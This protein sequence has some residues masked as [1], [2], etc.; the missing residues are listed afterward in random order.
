MNYPQY[1]P[2]KYTIWA[3]PHPY[4]LLFVLNPGIAINE[5]ILGQRKP[6][7]TLI[8]NTI[9]KP[10]IERIFIPCPHCGKLHDA[11]LWDNKN[12]FGHWFGYV[13]PACSEIIP[14]LWNLT[15]LVILAIT[16][17]IWFIPARLWKSKW[18][19]F[20][21]TRF[22]KSP[23]QDYQDISWFKMGFAYGGLLWLFLGLVPL[24]CLSSISTKFPWE[25]LI[26][27]LIVCAIAGIFFGSMMKFQ[28]GKRPNKKHS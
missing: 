17:P 20:E 3:F 5:L 21:K 7:V 23:T 16:S 15:S 9:D 8:D 25:I 1:D 27:S 19:D 28:S 22:G 14:C 13:C 11:R 4:I 24:I 26:G 10:F 18:I 2:V 12:R 6:K